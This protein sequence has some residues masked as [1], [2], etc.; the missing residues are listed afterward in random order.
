MAAAGALGLPRGWA[1]QGADATSQPNRPPVI[2]RDCP[3]YRIYPLRNGDLAI[4]G[5]H[6]FK[7]GDET[8][9]YGYRLYSFLILGGEKP[10]LVDAGLVDVA[11]MNRGAAKVLAEPITQKPEHTIPRQLKKFG[12]AP[13][14]IGHVFVTHLHF[15][16]VD[17]LDAYTNAIV[18]IGNKEWE[19]ATA[20]RSRSWGHAR[21]LANFIDNPQWARRLSLCEDEE[22][23]PGIESFWVGGH[24]PGSMAYSVNT[25]AGRTVCTGDTVSLL[26]N[27]ERDVAVGVQVSQ[28]ECMAGM[29]RIRE[30]ADF[31]LPSH[32][33]GTL[34]RWPPVPPGTPRYTIRAI[35]VGQ[36]EVRDQVTYHG[37]TSR[38][39]QTYFLYVWAIL[40][41]DKPI[42]VET[43]PNPKY[44]EEFNRGTAEYIPG[45]VKQTP[46]E[47]TP[48]ALKRYGIDPA[49]VSH[50]IITH[51]HAD[52]YDWFSL[53]SNARLVVNETEF[54][55]NVHRL[56]PDVLKAITARRGVLQIVEDE[57]VVPGIR[58]VP[59]GC[60][61]PGSQGVLV[62][63]WV[64]PA[65][66]TG[67]VVYLYENIEKNRPG[68]SPDK[69]ACVDA[70]AR[71]RNLADIVLPAHDPRTLER[72]PD[73]IIGE[74]PLPYS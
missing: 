7:G 4:N 5:K 18:H 30:R 43:G 38:D 41:G 66:L 36:C 9:T 2:R 53:F 45:G 52:H 14:D 62:Q 49:D 23:L 72:W 44:V 1:A 26:A 60:H 20:D 68:N 17:G 31:V 57:E 15:D 65:M 22:I 46:E 55:Q 61:T 12:L 25:A 71:I 16:H 47:L 8:E 34:L 28:D 27:L 21:I 56:N 3:V 73:G 40:G 51:T 54:E 63:T 33:P 32:D 74:K 48:E 19:L 39:T 10:M 50:V 64:G 13:E 6:A 11:E 59:L 67:D 69:Q 37:S 24:T 58:T 35:K 70:M 42:I 29:Q